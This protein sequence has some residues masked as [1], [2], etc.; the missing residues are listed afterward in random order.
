MKRQIEEYL[1]ARGARYFRGHHDDEYFFF[2][3]FLAGADRGRLDVHLDVCDDSETVQVTI[4]PDRYYPAERT[5]R[6]AALVDRWNAGA[7]AVQAVVHGSC[8]PRLVGVQ[9]RG[10]A[11]PADA[12]SLSGFVDG[13]V[14]AGIDLFGG[15]ATAA[16]PVPNAGLR[17]AG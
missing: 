17:D 14:A 12:A 13:A 15:I 11:R 4:S 8:D 16:A 7:P 10:S 5:S 6:L 2:V 3:D 1:R 9:A